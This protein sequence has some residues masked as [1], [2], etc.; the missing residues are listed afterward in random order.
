MPPD[1]S[2][3]A[4]DALG[5]FPKSLQFVLARW[6]E[7]SD[8]RGLNVLGTMAHY[9]AL[10]KAFMTFNAHVAGASTLSARV[11][12]LAILRLSWLL[13]SEYELVQHIILGLRA[14]LTDA[15]IERTQAGPDAPGWSAEDADLLRAVDELHAQSGIQKTTLTQLAG[16]F[17][18]DQLM[19][20]VFLMGC[21][22]SLGWAINSFSI[23]LDPDA[24]PL[25]PQVRARL[26]KAKA[27]ISN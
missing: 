25:A 13:R 22:T 9:P 5:A 20:L 16:R 27:S 11:R 7:G 3:A 18:N 12:E 19:D 26:L 15:E 23:A 6:K 17:S 10:T 14:G 2:E 4:L 24:T 21:Y 8:V 1:W